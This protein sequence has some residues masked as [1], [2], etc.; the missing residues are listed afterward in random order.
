MK[1]KFTNKKQFGKYYKKIIKFNIQE[2]GNM[3]SS[4]NYSFHNLP[5]KYHNVE[6]CEA[7]LFAL[8]WALHVLF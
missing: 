8:K 7:Y 6:C 3:I 4:S 2:A 1:V 5:E